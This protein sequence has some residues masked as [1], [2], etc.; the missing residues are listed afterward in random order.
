MTLDEH[1]WKIMTG[2]ILKLLAH[3]D[4]P[5]RLEMYSNCHKYVK[6]VLGGDQTPRLSVTK[7]SQ[8][9]FLCNTQI[10]IEIIC[11]GASSLNKKVWF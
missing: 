5:V 7:S 1:S 10:L 3:V 9:S 8:L 2:V 4:Q 6:A 11:H